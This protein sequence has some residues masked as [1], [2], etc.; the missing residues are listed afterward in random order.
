MDNSIASLRQPPHSVEAEQALLAAMVERNSLINDLDFLASD[1]FFRYEHQ[2]IF[3][4]LQALAFLGKP[5]DAVTLIEA[6]DGANNLEAAGGVDYIADMLTQSR[7][8]HNAKA[9]AEI[10]ADKSRSRRLIQAAYKIA[11][12][13]YE[14]NDS[15]ASIDQAQSLILGLTQAGSNE[16]QSITEIMKLAVDDIDRRFHSRGEMVGL[17][18]GFSELD[19]LTSGFQDGQLIIIAGRPSMGKTTL[20]M[21]IAE[22]AMLQDKFVVAFNLEMTSTTLVTKTLSSLGRIPY[23]LLKKG[24]IEEHGANLSAAGGKIKGRPLY[25]DDS[26]STLSTQVMSRTRKIEGKMGRKVD[27]VVVDYLQLLNDKGDGTERITRISRALKIAAKELNCP[28]IAL[29]QLNR[30]VEDRSDK[31]PQMADLR[32]SGAIE[33]DADIIIMLYRDEVYN[34]QSSEKGIAHAIVRK[35]REG[36]TGTVY[37]KSNLHLCRFD[38]LETV[39]TPSPMAP[40]KSKGFSY[41]D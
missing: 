12:M 13:G 6:I 27:L 21:N 8:P 40:T 23:E 17:S 5:V 30:K 7:G 11:E 25:I 18:T 28:V 31:R 4:Q 35:N 36:E 9:Y 29:S 19:K 33:Q 3:T 38:N 10:V 41:A 14:E 16:P 37:L 20:A 34:E 15:I 1:D 24:R 26:A 22:N 2:I 32:E 39:F